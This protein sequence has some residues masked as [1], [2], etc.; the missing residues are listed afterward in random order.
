MSPADFVYNQIYKGSLAL[1]IS[2]T[3][4]K[5]HAVMGLDRYKK[6]KFQKNKVDL[7]IKEQIAAAKKQMKG[8]KS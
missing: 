1:K 6:N 2:E 3:I 4:A 5:N 7:L 8:I